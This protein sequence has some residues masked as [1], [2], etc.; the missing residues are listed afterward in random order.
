MF[1]NHAEGNDNTNGPKKSKINVEIDTPVCIQ[2][3]LKSLVQSMNLLRMN[4]LL[5]MLKGRD[6]IIHY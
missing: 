4:E 6:K 3:K 2:K 1:E 5:G